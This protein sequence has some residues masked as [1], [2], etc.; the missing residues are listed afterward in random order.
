MH[1]V[2]V[3]DILAQ[4]PAAYWITDVLGSLLLALYFGFK[5]WGELG[6]LRQKGWAYLADWY[7]YVEFLVQ[8]LIV[9]FFV[10][11]VRMWMADD[12]EVVTGL[13]QN[14]RIVNITQILL[15]NYQLLYLIRIFDFFAAFVRSLMEILKDSAPIGSVLI[16][17][18]ITQG[19]LFY[20][21]D[22]NQ[23]EPAFHG[24][25]LAGLG[26]LFVNSY[27]LTLG[28]FE[29]TGSFEDTS[30]PVFFW[31]TFVLGTLVSLL[32]LLNM[33][34][35][36]MSATFECVAAETEAHLYREKLIAILD[37][38]H[39]FPD[40]TKKEFGAH[41]YLLLL[42]VDP[43]VDPIADDTRENRVTGELA[44]LQE[45]FEQMK[46]TQSQVFSDILALHDKISSF[47]KKLNKRVPLTTLIKKKTVQG[48]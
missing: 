43:E 11:T 8:G 27:R 9:T 45:D 15:M 19:M 29:L 3:T 17:I 30:N 33:V 10:M 47:E 4:Y 31:L 18:T 35:A 5:A 25:G 44:G 6:E 32:I 20:V 40:S 28:D 22:M 37:K 14:L 23:T 13:K 12:E 41:K 24:G 46:F 16:F 1:L 34:I 2:A 48:D 36:V 21:L 7:N 26:N 42:E 38:I 39:A